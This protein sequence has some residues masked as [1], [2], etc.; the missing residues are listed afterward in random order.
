MEKIEKL[1]LLED[2]SVTVEQR[3]FIKIHNEIMTYGRVTCEFAIKTAEKLK[4]MRDGKLY[5]SAG[6]QT[7]G[8]YVE[9]AVGLKERQAYNYIKAYEDLPIDFLQSNA[10]IGITKLTLLSTI[11][12][13][14]REELVK[15]NDLEKI[16]VKEL[17]AEIE[18]YKKK[19]EQ[20]QLELNDN[21]NS[22]ADE[23]QAEI[24]DLKDK[25]EKNLEKLKKDKEK[26]KNEIE[27]LK[28]QPQ[29][30][31]TIYQDN[32]K[33]ISQLADANRLLKDKEQ[34]LKNKE[35]EIIALNKKILS[36]DNSMTVFKIKFDTIQ[37]DMI[38][39]IEA[40]DNLP[41]DRKEKCK[42]AINAV[43]ER[44]KL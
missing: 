6:F 24:E 18:K 7:F 26:L 44:N 42:M 35:A 34:E 1:M 37:K 11:A 14:D 8:E 22:K 9:N 21:S 29:K 19:I 12:S 33:T 16:S 30:I 23:L 31:E 36:T 41:V 38:E 20:L 32:P 15:N 28:N 43:L 17:Q 2:G 3:N 27:K 40:Y 13:S 10:K 5:L 4:E 39:L 25:N